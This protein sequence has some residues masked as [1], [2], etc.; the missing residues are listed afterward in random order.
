MSA[1]PGLF[2]VSALLPALSQAKGCPRRQVAR[3][4]KERTQRS[5]KKLSR[6]RRKKPLKMK[7]GLEER[8]RER[9]R[10]EMPLSSHFFL[11][12]PQLFRTFPLFAFTST[13]HWEVLTQARTSRVVERAMEART[14]SLERHG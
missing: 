11:S 13:R 8:E 14:R 7:M 1:I 6:S 3:A 12:Q 4:E 2:P 10:D 9:E 5:E